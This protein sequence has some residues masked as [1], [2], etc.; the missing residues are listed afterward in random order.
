MAPIVVVWPTPNHGFTRTPE[1]AT[2]PRDP[3]RRDFAE[4]AAVSEL[5]QSVKNRPVMIVNTPTADVAAIATFACV[6]WLRPSL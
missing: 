1:S 4:S 5:S 6:W 3:L 2:E